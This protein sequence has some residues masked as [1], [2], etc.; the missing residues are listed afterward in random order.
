MNRINIKKQKHSS[1]DWGGYD[2]FIYDV[3]NGNYYLSHC[4]NSDTKA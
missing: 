1:V 3:A 4:S 2:D